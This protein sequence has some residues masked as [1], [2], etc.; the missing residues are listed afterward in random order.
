MKRFI[1]FAVALL[2][3]AAITS[4]QNNI[5][6]IRGVTLIDGTG[7]GS[8][9][10]VTVVIEGNTIKDAGAH[11]QAP[12]GARTIDDTEKFLIPGI[13]DAHIHLLGG[14]GGAPAAEQERDGI[15]ALHSYLYAGVTSVFDV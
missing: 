8:V 4:A 12:A 10:N 13:I 3:A 2:A 9:P 6:V 7:R 15:R 1:C 11:V 14:R 5:I